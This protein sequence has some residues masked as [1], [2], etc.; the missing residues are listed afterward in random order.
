MP[1]HVKLSPNRV[2]NPLLYALIVR[3]IKLL[4]LDFPSSQKLAA[5]CFFTLPFIRL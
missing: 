3:A 2:Q 5:R 1:N 4:V